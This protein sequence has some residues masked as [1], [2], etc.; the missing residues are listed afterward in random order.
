M[1]A[2]TGKGLPS[3]QRDDA[4]RV[5]KVACLVCWWYRIR[6][7]ELSFPLIFTNYL[8]TDWSG[9]GYR[10]IASGNSV[11]FGI[12]A[13]LPDHRGPFEGKIESNEVNII[14]NRS[15]VGAKSRY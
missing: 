2:K 4:R 11:G 5:V 9:M 15:E 3:G 7:S 14:V 6:Y 13:G 1:F 8:K 10:D 12:A